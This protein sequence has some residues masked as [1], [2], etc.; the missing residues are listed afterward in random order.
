M[1]SFPDI[2]V[3]NT[4]SEMHRRRDT[5]KGSLKVKP[6][7][8]FKNLKYSINI[9]LKIELIHGEIHGITY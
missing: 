1:P 2:L 7:F 4:N 3:F 8:T 9:L 6:F 5:E